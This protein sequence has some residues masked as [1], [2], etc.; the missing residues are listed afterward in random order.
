MY[1]NTV[2]E[3]N[4]RDCTEVKL[5]TVGTSLEICPGE[6][7]NKSL[8]LISVRHQIIKVLFRIS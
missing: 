1:D 5:V 4:I 6:P 8:K 3:I 7:L 2:A